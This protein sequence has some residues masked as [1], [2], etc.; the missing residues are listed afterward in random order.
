MSRLP[1]F[2]IVGAAKSGTTSLYEYLRQ[3][4]QIFMPEQ[5]EPSFFAAAEAGGLNDIHSY[6][7][8]FHDVTDETAIGEA[9]VAYLAD[10]NAAQKIHDS[11]GPDTKI[12]VLL[13]NPV[14]MAYSLWGHNRRLGV[15]P[16]DFEDALEEEMGRLK[17]DTLEQ[18]LGT[19]RYNVTYKYRASYS[20]QLQPYLG[21]FNR[22]QIKIYIYEEFF[23]NGLPQ[24]NDL[25]HFLNVQTGHEPILKVHNQAG[26]VH[27][28]WLRYF[29]SNKSWLKEPVKFILPESWRN[30]ITALLELLNRKNSPLPPMREETRRH[31]EGCFSDSKAEL[32][33]IL[34]RKLNEVWF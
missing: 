4:P 3:H 26:T 1:N 19:W 2:L 5:K 13:R 31:L 17:N 24:Y 27:S 23:E 12:V 18:E 34:G 10:T 14:N 7:E 33:S 28:K 25:C 9:S 8:L 11:L 20:H 21:T 6:Q 29:L 32:E 15:E 30:R 16:L 22:K